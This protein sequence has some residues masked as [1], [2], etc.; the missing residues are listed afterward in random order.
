MQTHVAH[1][2]DCNGSTGGEDGIVVA[3]VISGVY[4]AEE[5]G[6][7]LGFLKDESVAFVRDHG[8]LFVDLLA[9]LEERQT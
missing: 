9:G 6:E 3:V 5:C 4:Q 7:C 8:G 2:L 1:G